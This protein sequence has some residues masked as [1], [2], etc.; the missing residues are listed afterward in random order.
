MNCARPIVA[1]LMVGNAPD[2]RSGEAMGLKHT[3]NH[4]ARL[5]FPVIAGSIACGSRLSFILPM[6][7]F[8]L[9]TPDLLGRPENVNRDTP[10]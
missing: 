4:L 9:G 7:G 8:R 10:R 1:M 3:V 6:N 5:V 2:G